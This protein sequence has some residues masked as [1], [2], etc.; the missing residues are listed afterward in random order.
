M[1]K[2]TELK[3]KIYIFI[4]VNIILTII[5]I[6]FYYIN[7]SNN[8]GLS[9][10]PQ[11]WAWFGDYLGGTLGSTFAFTALMAL[12]YSIYL[13][14]IELR[15]STEQLKKSAE[16]L[17]QQNSLIQKQK[18]ETTFFLLLKIHIEN[19]Q[20]LLITTIERD[21]NRRDT[22]VKKVNKECI[23]HLFFELICKLQAAEYNNLKKNQDRLDSISYAFDTIYLE[24]GNIIES[25]IRSIN[26]IL[27]YLDN[28][29]L[30][31]DEKEIYSEILRSQFT[32]TELNFIL[33]YSVSEYGKQKTLPL[34]KKQNLL[35]HRTMDKKYHVLASHDDILL[36]DEIQPVEQ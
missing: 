21:N 16:A 3:T 36:I 12:L 18:I 17:E 24:R 28:I 34:I 35:K 5:V 30:S 25:Y 23:D 1:K 27:D 22:E 32:N 7:I 2:L 10:E 29:L 13:Q 11:L 8:S 20:A 19:V 6:G 15:N 26:I 31:N 9:K 4:L 33:Y 14:N